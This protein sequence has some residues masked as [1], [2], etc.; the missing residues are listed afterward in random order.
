MLN[1]SNLV[2]VSASRATSACLAVPTFS[3][4]GT[5]CKEVSFFVS[6]FLSSLSLIYCHQHA[7]SSTSPV[8]VRISFQVVSDVSLAFPPPEHFF[9][10]CW[11]IFLFTWPWTLTTFD[12][13]FVSLDLEHWLHLTNISFHVTSNTFFYFTNTSFQL[14]LKTGRGKTFWNGLAC[15]KSRI[16]RRMFEHL[17]VLYRTKDTSSWLR[18]CSIFRQNRM[19]LP[20]SLRLWNKSVL[21]R[22]YSTT[23]TTLARVR[24]SRQK[25]TT[26]KK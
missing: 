13:C 15:N 12:Q 17:T 19:A 3:M 21:V 7:I 22:E 23:F 1:V 8:G 6:Y 14:T 24:P 4:F 10:H 11:P 9:F 25:N 2:R 20:S 18:A 5:I 16:C 26:H